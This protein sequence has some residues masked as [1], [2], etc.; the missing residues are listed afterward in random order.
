[1]AEDFV[2]R[3]QHRADLAELRLELKEE[4]AGMRQDV[5]VLTKTVEHM[6]QTMQQGFSDLRADMRDLRGTTQR[7]LWVMVGVVVAAV[8]SGLVK[9]LLLP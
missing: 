3:D 1:M 9:L 5:A 2:S 6:Q 4:V 7:Q 8:L